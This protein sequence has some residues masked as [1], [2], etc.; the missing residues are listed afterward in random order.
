MT[1]DLL[2]P[3]LPAAALAIGLLFHRH[4]AAQLALLLAI[5]VLAL[6][7]ADP[8]RELAALGFLPWLALLSA[9]LPEGRLLSRRHLLW[10]ALLAVLAGTA[11]DAPAR[12]FDSM[13]HA[14]ANLLGS[15][16]AVAAAVGFALAAAICLLRWARQRQPVELASA[17]ALIAALPALLSPPLR[18]ASL[19]LAALLLLAGVL[20]GSYRMAFVDQLTGLPNRRALDETLGRLSGDYRL[21][22]LDIDHFKSFNDSHGHDAGDVV[23]RE[24][25]RQLARSAGGRAFRYGGEEFCVVY[26]GTA[27]EQAE[28]GLEQARASIEARRIAILPAGKRHRPAKRTEVAV[29]ISA[30]CAARDR[31]RRSPPEV[32]KAADQALYKAKKKGRNRVVMV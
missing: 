26:P 12:L 8:R 30:G 32:M 6:D 25:A 4:R 23:L 29:T 17:L 21:A 14:L 19:A 5:A 2:L 7:A 20:Y 22:M 28:A 18:D 9:A 10:L 1:R 3:L 13:A 24:V 27:R 16:P 11:I 15:T 31:D